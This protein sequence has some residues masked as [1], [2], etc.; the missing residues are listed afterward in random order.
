MPDDRGQPNDRQFL[1]REQRGESFARHRTAAD[2][3][4]PHRVAKALA[5]H[6]HQVRA[7]AI[8][9]FFRRNQKDLAPDVASRTRRCHAGSPWMKRPAFSAPSIMAC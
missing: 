2:A 5:Q 9:G 8:A 3:L 7:E 6:F 4:E 1:D